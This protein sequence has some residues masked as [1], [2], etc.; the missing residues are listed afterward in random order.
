MNPKVKKKNQKTLNKAVADFIAN[1]EGEKTNKIFKPKFQV[2]RSSGPPPDENR[3]LGKI[4]PE[5]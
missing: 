4:V 1:N 5:K 2:R 3:L